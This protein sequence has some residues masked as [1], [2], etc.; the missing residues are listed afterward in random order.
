[1]T[2]TKGLVLWLIMAWVFWQ[3]WF[4][5]SEYREWCILN[6]NLFRPSSVFQQYNCYTWRSDL[7]IFGSLLAF[8]FMKWCWDWWLEILERR[9]IRN[10]G[11]PPGRNGGSGAQCTASL[12]ENTIPPTWKCTCGI[13]NNMN[14]PKCPECGVK[15]DYVLARLR[16]VTLH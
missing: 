2:R 7:Y 6:P 13:T 12:P 14:L 3:S 5:F 4:M 11:L 8:C 15:R 9:R 16:K 1:M 10:E